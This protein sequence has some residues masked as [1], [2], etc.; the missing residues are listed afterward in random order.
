VVQLVTPVFI[1]TNIPASVVVPI[2]GILR[3]HF[4][5]EPGTALLLGVGIA[6]LAAVGQRRDARNGRPT[7]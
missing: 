7:T 5:P 2:F 3:L 1:A 6:G 4:A